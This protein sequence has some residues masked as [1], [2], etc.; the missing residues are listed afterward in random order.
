[1]AMGVGG[2]GG[3]VATPG[4]ATRCLPHPK[5]SGTPLSSDGCRPCTHLGAVAT[6]CPLAPPL[7]HTLLLHPLSPSPS[8]ASQRAMEGGGAHC[9]FGP[10]SGLKVTLSVSSREWLAGWASCMH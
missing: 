5:L 3:G 1:M 10:T 2:G 7:P 8:H 4:L 6:S 9:T